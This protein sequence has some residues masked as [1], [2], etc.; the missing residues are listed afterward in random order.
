MLTITL[1]LSGTSFI[2]KKKR[3]P[4]GYNNVLVSLD[5]F[6]WDYNRLY[7][8]LNLNMFVDRGVKADK[9]YFSFSTITFPD[10]YSIVS[11]L[12]PDH[13][14]IIV[15]SFPAANLGLYFRMGDRNAVENPVY[16]I[17]PSEGKIDII[18]YYINKAPGI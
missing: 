15:S 17:N 10:H 11:G 8:T 9:M 6:R 5:A 18:L 12:Y 1:F 7:N 3:S 16:I 4:F 14:G 13:K 2:S